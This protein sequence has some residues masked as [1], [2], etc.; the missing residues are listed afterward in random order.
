M[1]KCC[2]CNHSGSCIRCSCTKTCRACTGCVPLQAHLCRNRHNDNTAAGLL[3]STSVSIGSSASLDAVNS[4]HPTDPETQPPELS[5]T[6][7]TMSDAPFTWGGMSNIEITP[8]IE[9]AYDTIIHWRKN[10]MM[11]PIGSACND[12]IKELTTRL[13][14]AYRDASALERIALKGVMVLQAA[15]LQ[16][17]SRTSKA[18][19]H[20]RCV[21]RWMK[22]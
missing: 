18:K 17:P 13:L 9:R 19:D 6:F 14:T 22:L 8:D 4:N 21:E 10:S 2:K 5:P 12:F 16:K 3:N 20:L 7:C 11:L 15:V 1:S